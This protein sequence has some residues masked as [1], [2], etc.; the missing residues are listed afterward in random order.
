MELLKKEIYLEKAGTLTDFITENEKMSVSHLKLSGLLN[1]KDFDVLD[2]M[3]TSRVDFDEDD[4]YTIIE[5]KSPFLKVLDLGDSILL[6]DFVLGGFTYYSKLDKIVLPKNME[7]TGKMSVFKD[8]INLKTVV[9]PETLKEYGFGTFMNC[10]KLEE[11]NFPTT[12]ERIGGLSFYGCS[13]LKRIKIPANVSIIEG[14]AF[15][16]CNNLETFEIDN[17]NTNFVVIDGVIYNHDKTKL[18][19]FP[20]GYKDKHFL[21]PEGLKII[22]DGSFLNS[23]ITSINFPS[24]LE[25]IK[26]WAFSCCSNLQS[27]DIPNSVLEIGEMAFEDCSA[28]NHVKLPNCLAIL[29]RQ[30]FSGCDS[31][32]EIDIPES[33][34]VI[35]SASLGWSQGLENIIL[36]DGLEVLNILTQSEVLKNIVIPKTVK[37]IASGIFRQCSSMNQIKID[38]K[39]PYFCTIDGSL[40]STD[41][42]KLIAVPFNENKTIV[43]PDGVQIIEDIVFEGFDKLEQLVLPQ[44][45]KIIGHRAFD[46]CKGLKAIHFP[47][48]VTSIDFRAFDHCDNLEIIEIEAETPPEITDPLSRRWKFVGYTKDVILYV[49]KNSLKEYK[50]AFG[51][52]DIKNIEVLTQ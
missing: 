4:N 18:V 19:A 14:G 1:L 15:A 51:W 28:L 3:C 23:P 12:L 2:T 38:N 52:K 10:E 9:V 24:S 41:K 32:K 50:K 35:E 5:D 6:D 45:L 47:K 46:G 49:P 44:T 31:L 20:C 11:V 17:R 8:S 39:N 16:G 7:S 21:V 33:V 27:L 34:K 13:A 25:I 30:T 42:K 26:D 37:E 43:L 36:H 22:G 40:Y 48:F 29:K